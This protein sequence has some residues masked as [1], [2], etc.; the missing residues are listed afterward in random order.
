MEAATASERGKDNTPDPGAVVVA[1]EHF[2]ATRK[3]LAKG[4]PG[5]AECD[6][7]SDSEEDF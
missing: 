4:W 7:E 2:N 5:E 3:E 6:G 1:A